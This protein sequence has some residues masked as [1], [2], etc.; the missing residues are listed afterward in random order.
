MFNLL[1]GFGIVVVLCGVLVLVVKIVDKAY[2]R[3]GF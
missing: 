1:L 2:E 3:W